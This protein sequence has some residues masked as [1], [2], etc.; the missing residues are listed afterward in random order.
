[1]TKERQSLLGLFAV[2][3]IAM[4]I[5]LGYAFFTNQPTPTPETDY[6]FTGIEAVQEVPD[7]DLIDQDGEAITLADLKG[8]MSLIAFGFTNCPDVCPLTL[9]EFKQIQTALGDKS[10]GINFVFISVDG[11]R[12]TPQVLTGY[13]ERMGVETFVGITGDAEAVRTFG[14]PFNLE[15]SYNEPNATGY[16]TV[17]HTAHYFLL[18]EEGRWITKINYGTLRDDIQAELEKQL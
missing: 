16:Y 6:N 3:A 7:F 18:D 1:M 13:F 2:F 17:A 9:N 12:D 14:A 8:K 4:A 15:F 10:E 5:L 11:E